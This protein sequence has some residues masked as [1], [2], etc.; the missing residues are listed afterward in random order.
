LIVA[1]GSKVVETLG[2]F[3]LPVEVIPL[4][5]P[6][7]AT[8][9]RAMGVEPS[10]RKARKGD[11][12]F[13]TDEGNRILDCPFGAIEDPEGLAAAL[14]AMPGVVEHGL[15]IDLA[16][17]AYVARDDAIERLVPAGV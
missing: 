17:E 11:Q 2:A 10:L 1:D 3:A 15:F 6:L 14:C 16:T 5:V 12:P 7:V 13:V 4:A 9:I 8:R